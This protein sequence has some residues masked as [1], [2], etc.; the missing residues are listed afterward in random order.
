MNWKCD[1]VM[2]LAA[3]YHDGVASAGSRR[4]VREHLRECPEC[5]AQYRDY[6]PAMRKTRKEVVQSECG[7][8]IWLAKRMRMRRALIFAGVVSYVSATL[9]VF[10][11]HIL[12]RRG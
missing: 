9:C 5:R 8:Y 12:H 7:Q 3:L 1:V 4:F 11:L 10:A 6:R 2:D